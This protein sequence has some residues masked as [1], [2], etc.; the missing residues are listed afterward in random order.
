MG[1]WLAP[2]KKTRDAIATERY[3]IMNLPH[4]CLNRA[5]NRKEESEDAGGDMR[6]SAVMENILPPMVI[7]FVSYYMCFYGSIVFPLSHIT[8]SNVVGAN[9]LAL[10]AKQER[11]VSP[12]K[13]TTSW[14]KRLHFMKI[15]VFRNVI[16]IKLS[17]YMP[18]D[19]ATS[20]DSMMMLRS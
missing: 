14:K 19:L 13:V 9:M 5:A 12:F 15:K 17:Q 4:R 3:K 18:S 2:R 11:D 20:S 10:L 16:D 6:D 1:D 7:F 8:I